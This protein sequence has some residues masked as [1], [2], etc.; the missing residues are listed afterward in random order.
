MWQQRR[1][2]HKLWQ[3]TGIRLTSWMKRVPLTWTLVCACSSSSIKSW[4]FSE[5]LCTQ[6][7][8]LQPAW[9][10]YT[11][12]YK[13]PNAPM[14]TFM[15]P[16]N[17]Y[18]FL[19]PL[20]HYY[21]P[22]LRLLSL[23]LTVLTPSAYNA[24]HWALHCYILGLTLLSHGLIVV[25]AG[26]HRAAT[27]V[28]HLILKSLHCGLQPLL[29]HTHATQVITQTYHSCLLRGLCSSYQVNW[30]RCKK[31]LTASTRISAP[32]VLSR[33]RRSDA[34]D[35]R[36]SLAVWVVYTH[37]QHRIFFSDYLSTSAW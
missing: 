11:N 29:P 8:T 9:P 34:L 37:T 5:K 26:T 16:T 14:I 2:G 20:G 12:K 13:F 19:F 7:P 35:S 36:L 17:Q 27:G 6:T 18:K 31:T 33:P 25:L 30:A 3:Y 10:L 28:G 15:I 4:V 1:G 23:T 32:C 22:S 24:I 21:P